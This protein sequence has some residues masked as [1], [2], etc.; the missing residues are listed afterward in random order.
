[1][2]SHRMTSR[3]HKEASHKEDEGAEKDLENVGGRLG[4]GD[5][6]RAKR[7][8]SD[9]RPTRAPMCFASAT[10]MQQSEIICRVSAASRQTIP[11]SRQRRQQNE[12][13]AIHVV[14][15]GIKK[16]AIATAHAHA[17]RA[18][19]STVSIETTTLHI[20]ACRRKWARRNLQ[21]ALAP[22][23]PTKPRA[24]ASLALNAKQRA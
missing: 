11:Q 24:F 21:H 2:A 18:L 8:R 16:R 13:S 14:S 6:V 7:L 23:T 4:H 12:H 15:A 1:M 10:S 9:L 17:R 19:K 20:D 22:R 5:D 3:S